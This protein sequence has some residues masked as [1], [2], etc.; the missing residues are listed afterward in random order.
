M[1]D[2]EIK[3]KMGPLRVHGRYRAGTEW[4][5]RLT[6]MEIERRMDAAWVMDE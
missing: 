4:F 5:R 1:R 2:E 3:L 6:S